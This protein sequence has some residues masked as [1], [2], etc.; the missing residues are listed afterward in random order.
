MET[1]VGSILVNFTVVY[2]HCP[3]DR[4]HFSIISKL[5]CKLSGNLNEKVFIL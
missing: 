5:V 3:N 2:Q 4:K 1:D